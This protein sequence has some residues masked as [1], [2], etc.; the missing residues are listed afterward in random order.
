[1]AKLEVLKKQFGFDT[2]KS[3]QEEAIDKIL[4]KEDLLVILPTGSGKSLIY[5]LPTLMM[6][7]VTVVISPL[8]ALMQDQVANLKV[9]GIKS[10]MINSQ[11]TSEENYAIFNLALQKKIKFL[12]IAPER[13]ANESFQL[14]LK[15]L[16]IN[17]F[18]IDEAHCVSEWG[19]EFRDDYRKLAYLKDIFPNTPISAFTATATDEVKND[20]L[21]TL[22]IPQT[23]LLKSKIQRDNLFIEAQKRVGNA[24]KQIT[25]F[26]KKHPNECGIVYCFSR[27]ECESLSE[28]LNSEGF[29][30]LAYHA[31]LPTSKREDIFNKF[32]DE[33]VK[34]IVATIAFGMGIDKSNIR[35][36]LHTSMPKTLEN[37][38][39]EIGRAGRDGLD[40]YTLL[41]YSKADEIGKRR[42]IDELE[43]SAYKQNSYNKLSKMY[44]FAS[45]EVCRHQLIATYFNDEIKKCESL[46]DNCTKKDRNYQD[47]TVEA[48]KFLSTIA[49][50]ESRFGQSYI[51]DVLRGSKAKRILD[52]G[53]DKL[54][55]YGIGSDKSKE[56]W[57]GVC[58]R[59]LDLEAIAIGGEYRVL[60][61]LP[62]S[63]EILKSNLKVEIDVDSLKVEKLKT[64][65]IQ[66]EP[67]SVDEEI[68]NQ[69]R[70]IRRELAKSEGVPPY[71][72]FSDKSLKEIASYLPSNKAEFMAINGVGEMKLEKYG[73]VFIEACKKIK[74][75]L[76][77]SS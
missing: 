63:K 61:L 2:F 29:N 8:I 26:L 44:R 23:S 34:I 24:K 69:L 11:N 54:S 74:L 32:K 3:I 37:Y 51:I 5:Q 75:S 15:K 62:K 18:V 72:I 28:Y 4:A 39:Q 65:A 12:Y 38:T 64:K 57:S 70:E 52:F 20:I 6:D 13:M 30:T 47:I 10:G 16:D 46:C 9:L 25:N 27:K 60:K 21:H 45:S 68:F 58:D 19:H 7:G 31:G 14:I 76:Q 41:L 36:V 40:S 55:V 67:L 48:Q 49:R 22:K 43:E 1:M 71:I 33:S 53:H 42:F 73:K 77:T 66:K 35:F 17:Y 50:C 59:L 56:F